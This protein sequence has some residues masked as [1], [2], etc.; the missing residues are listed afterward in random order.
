MRCVCGAEKSVKYRNKYNLAMCNICI[1][2]NETLSPCDICK[3]KNLE[4]CALKE[5]GF[6]T[7]MYE[8]FERREFVFRTIDSFG[9]ITIPKEIR[10][11]AKIKEGDKFQFEIPKD[12]QILL[13]R[14]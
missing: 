3:H 5:T 4:K 6:Q 9:K 8:C 10:K 2:Q 12:G 11:Q 1:L 7:N 14:I 13:K